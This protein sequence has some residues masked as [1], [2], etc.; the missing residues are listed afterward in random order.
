MFGIGTHVREVNGNTH[1]AKEATWFGGDDCC[2]DT[3]DGDYED[4][5][6]EVE[7]DQDALSMFGAAC[8]PAVWSCWWR[9]DSGGADR[10][11]GFG[12][13]REL[14]PSSAR[15]VTQSAGRAANDEDYVVRMFH[16]APSSAELAAG[17]LDGGRFIIYSDGGGESE[18]DDMHVL[19][20]DLHEFSA[21]WII[22]TPV[23]DTQEAG[24]AR[25]A[26]LGQ[27]PVRQK[28]HSGRSSAMQTCSRTCG[29]GSPYRRKQRMAARAAHT[30]TPTHMCH[31]D[32][33]AAH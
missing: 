7:H 30:F 15:A 16:F 11:V 18:I 8:R 2:S 5:V 6:A 23:R 25:A 28:K 21:T 9:S 4:E 13:S 22:A 29:R 27:R 24:V 33:R 26:A 20:F 14:Q 12:D 1:V 19:H 10:L 32:V 17:A 31:R 3:D